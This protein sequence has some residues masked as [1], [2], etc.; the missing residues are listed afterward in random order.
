MLYLVYLA[1]DEKG[2][3]ITGDHVLYVC[4]KY[5]AKRGELSNDTVVTTVMSN[6]GL[7]KAFDKAGILA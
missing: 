1:V 6:F 7:Y 5:M 4:G 2:N 3:I